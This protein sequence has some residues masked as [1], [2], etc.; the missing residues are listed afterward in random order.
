ML[1]TPH[2]SE[3][4]VHPIHPIAVRVVGLAIDFNDKN[5]ATISRCPE[6]VAMG[7]V[8]CAFEPVQHSSAAD[9]FDRYDFCYAVLENETKFNCPNDRTCGVCRLHIRLE[10][11]DWANPS[12]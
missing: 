10:K 5:R 12:L 9:P 7:L 2:V 4:A 6:A 11:T 1:A 8:R 3:L